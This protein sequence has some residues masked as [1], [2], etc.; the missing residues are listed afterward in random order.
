MRQ[1][2][3]GHWDIESPT[4]GFISFTHVFLLLLLLHWLFSSPWV[5]FTSGLFLILSL[6]ESHLFFF[7][8]AGFMWDASFFLFFLMTH[9]PHP[10]LSSSCIWLSSCCTS[11]NIIVVGAV[12]LY[13]T[14]KLK[15]NWGGWG[16]LCPPLASSRCQLPA[17]HKS[18][19][20]FQYLTKSRA[21]FLSFL[22]L[23]VGWT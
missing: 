11:A 21:D 6:F 14:W 15:Y 12:V 3:W 22:L 7:Q 20:L 8:W 10:L 9:N 13:C 5:L 23:L 4:V 18:G 2:D 16:L 19:W 17:R 1:S